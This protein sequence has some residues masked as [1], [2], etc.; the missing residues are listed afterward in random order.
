MKTFAIIPST[1]LGD[2][3]ITLGLAYNLSKD[4]KVVVYHPLIKY[5]AAFFPYLVPKE[6]PID[7]CD[8]DN[9]KIDQVLL[10]WE[11]SSFFES[12]ENVLRKRLGNNLYVLNPVV[13]NKKDYRFS[14]EYFFNC[15][16]SFSEN[17]NMFSQQKLG[18][19]APKKT[20]G[21]NLSEP[22]DPK[23][24]LMHVT[25]SIPRKCWPHSGFFFLKK[26]LE[27]QG[28]KVL[29]A[30]LPHEKETVD[31]GLYSGIQSLEELAMLL[32]KASLLIGNE[33]GVGHLASALHTPSII[34][35]RNPRRGNFWGADFEGRKKLICPPRWIP[36]MKPG[37][38]RDRY[39]KYLI[40]KNRVLKEIKKVL[41][42]N[43]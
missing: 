4:F 27:K 33:S 19:H 39:W 9:E 1:G 34:L 35:C 14:E 2:L 43:F 18:I 28:F 37:R 41:S 15:E 12:A 5:L 24:I 31:K 23:L 6:R 21:A 38:F 13:T 26:T 8:F 10:I 36:N 20:T 32:S 40:S 7:V 11:R 22:K 17:L 3:I 30:T 29:F 16:F 42:L 25:A